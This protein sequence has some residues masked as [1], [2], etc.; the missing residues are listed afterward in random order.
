MQNNSSEPD[1][2]DEGMLERS[3]LKFIRFPPYFT[4]RYGKKYPFTQKMS[5]ILDHHDRHFS[6]SEEKI[7]KWE[8]YWSFS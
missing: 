8:T 5:A 3:A 2:E 7:Q 4:A 6:M 1:M